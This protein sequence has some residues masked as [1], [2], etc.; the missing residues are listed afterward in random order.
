ME[1][2]LEP[3]VKAAKEAGKILEDNFSKTN[4]ITLKEGGSF[5][6]E[7]DKRAESKIISVIREKFPTH[8]INAE[9]SGLADE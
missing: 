4:P 7:I 9:E 2:M 8:S 1:N 3:A 6:T 5:V